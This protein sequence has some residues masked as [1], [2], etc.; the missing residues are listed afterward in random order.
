MA[1]WL[2]AAGFAWAAI[3]VAVECM[4]YNQPQIETIGFC[5]LFTTTMS[6]V[7]LFVVAVRARRSSQVVEHRSFRLAALYSLNGCV[8]ELP[9]AFVVLVGTSSPDTETSI[10]GVWNACT[11]YL[12]SRYSSSAIRELGQS[13]LDSSFDVQFD[14]TEEIIR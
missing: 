8:T 1:R 9:T 14:D 2:S 4:L 5:M 12:S 11:F 10:T 7:G 3:T 13:N 6:T